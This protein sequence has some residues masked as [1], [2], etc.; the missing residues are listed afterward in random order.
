MAKR[1]KLPKWAIKQ[2][3][4]INKKAW[5]LA[6]RGRKSTSR[7]RARAGN[8]R[9][10]P[11]RSKGR[12]MRRRKSFNIPLV[13]TAAGLA[14]FS[15]AKGSQTSKTVLADPLAALEKTGANLIANKKPLLVLESRAWR[16]N[17]FPPMSSEKRKLERLA[18]LNKGVKMALT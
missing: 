6:R 17:S 7:R 16:H 18:Q 14:L 15:L 12:T 10:T 1:G 8:R 13:K 9:R 5:R 2:A 3:G 4:G 11:A